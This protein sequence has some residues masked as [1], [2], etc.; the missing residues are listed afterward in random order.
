MVT[1]MLSSGGDGRMSLMF[2]AGR[3]RASTAGIGRR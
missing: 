1:P 2:S 3:E